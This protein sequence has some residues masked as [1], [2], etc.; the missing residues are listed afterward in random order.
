MR[1][2][3]GMD[4]CNMPSVAPSDTKRFSLRR[5]LLAS[6]TSKPAP[7]SVRFLVGYSLFLCAAFVAMFIAIR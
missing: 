4:T 3:I 5:L 7:G 1:Y 6:A 2:T